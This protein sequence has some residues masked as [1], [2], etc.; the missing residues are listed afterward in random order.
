MKYIFR[1]DLNNRLPGILELLNELSEKQRGLEYIEA[2]LRYIVNGAPA[3]NIN[4]EDL[5]A[6]VN[7]GIPHKGGEIMPTIADTLREQGMQ[8]G[9]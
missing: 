2:V 7:K 1:E 4:Y 3:D 9:M 6:A 5:N 8:Q